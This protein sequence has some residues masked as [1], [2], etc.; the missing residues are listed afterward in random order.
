MT[1][2]QL[3][4]QIISN[5]ISTEFSI[6]D[7]I[8]AL[9][10]NLGKPLDISKPAHRNFDFWENVIYDASNGKAEL[11]HFQRKPLLEWIQANY[12]HITQNFSTRAKITLQHRMT[13][14]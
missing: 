11:F 3:S 6:Q 9:W 5:D 2:I 10:Y 14:L 13:L 12:F 1:V 4:Q 8:D 7:F